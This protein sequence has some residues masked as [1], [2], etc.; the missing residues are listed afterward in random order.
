M[1]NRA[2]QKATDVAMNKVG[3]GPS[4]PPP[5]FPQSTLPHGSPGKPIV[6]NPTQV[7]SARRPLSKQG[8]AGSPGKLTL[9]QLVELTKRGLA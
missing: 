8:G 4:Q 6:G 7:P 1:A 9:A 2:G 3:L 5:P